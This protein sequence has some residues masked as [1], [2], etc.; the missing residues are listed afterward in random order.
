MLFTELEPRVGQSR[1]QF[2]AGTEFNRV[3]SA[4]RPALE[5][6]QLPVESIMTLLHRGNA[7]RHSLQ[8]RIEIKNDGSFSSTVP[9]ILMV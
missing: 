8:C 6:T 4:T 5:S 9:Y 7:V 2:P 3:S 1:V